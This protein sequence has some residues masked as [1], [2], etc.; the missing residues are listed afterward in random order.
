MEKKDNELIKNPNGQ[1][2]NY[3]QILRTLTHKKIQSLIE[4]FDDD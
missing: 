2:A 1:A 4:V 3:L